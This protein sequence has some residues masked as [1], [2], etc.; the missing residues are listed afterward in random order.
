MN[1][2][3]NIKFEPSIFLLTEKRDS[4][5]QQLTLQIPSANQLS[6]MQQQSQKADDIAITI[7]ETAPL[8]NKDPVI[9]IML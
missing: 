2:V 1:L 8:I 3:N 6:A 5:Q 7:D 9:T 4:E